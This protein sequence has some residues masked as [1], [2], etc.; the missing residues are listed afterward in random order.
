[1]IGRV[2]ILVRGSQR[3]QTVPIEALL[4]AD[5]DRA[6][7]FVLGPDGRAK[8][9]PVDVAFMRGEQAGIR[10]QLAGVSRV[11]TDGAAYLNDGAAVRVMP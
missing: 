10:G 2:E 4:E 3:V 8:R 7:L 9:V 1:M 5:G 11:I 6:T